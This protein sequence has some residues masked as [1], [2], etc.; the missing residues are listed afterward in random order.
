[1]RNRQGI[2]EVYWS[3]LTEDKRFTW[4]IFTRVLSLIAAWFV[5][6]TGC[7]GFDWIA[8]AFTAILPTLAI[9]SQR[10][11]RKFSPKVRKLIVRTII[12]LGSWGIAFL[13]VACIVQAG[14]VAIGTTFSTG[15]LPG[16][17]NSKSELFSII[18]IGIFVVASLIA[19]IRAV[20]QLNFEELIFRLP[21]AKLSELLI[22]RK[23]VASTFPL[24]AYF[25]LSTLL[26]G[27][28]YASLAAGLAKPFL[29]IFSS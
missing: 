13:G 4:K 23:F 3:S 21:R 20:R 9:E 1:M 2:T 11:Y 10:S 7:K 24:F 25:E 26:A 15:V 22:Q 14:I 27:F 29:L 16:L 28:A 17:K 19:I 8:S 6:K 5:L 12:F 18:F